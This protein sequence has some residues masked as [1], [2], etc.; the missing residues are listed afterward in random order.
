MHAVSRVR[1]ALGRIVASPYWRL[2]LVAIGITAV[3]SLVRPFD[4]YPARQFTGEDG[5]LYLEMT[6]ILPSQILE[7]K[8]FHYHIQRTF[9]SAVIWAVSRLL[10][11]PMDEAHGADRFRVLNA[12]WLVVGHGFFMATLRR[13]GVSV[14][15]AVLGTVLYFGSYL[16]A[17]YAFYYPQMTDV[18]ALGLGH[19]LAY[20]YV[21]RSRTLIL[22]VTLVGA[23]TWPYLFTLLAIPLALF[24]P[25]GGDVLSQAP[26]GRVGTLGAMLLGGLACF[27]V[28][29]VYF[30]L[31][32]LDPARF[33]WFYDGLLAAMWDKEYKKDYAPLFVLGWLPVAGVVAVA[34]AVLPASRLLRGIEL[35]DLVWRARPLLA[36]AVLG[37]AVGL[38][39]LQSRFATSHPLEETMH[40]KL[41]IQHTLTL[42]RPLLALVGHFAFL[43]PCVALFVVHWSGACF[44]ARRLGIGYAIAAAYL[45]LLLVCAETR[46]FLPGIALLLVPLVKAADD[47]GVGLPEIVVCAA[48]GA[49]TSKIWLLASLDPSAWQHPLVRGHFH[50]MPQQLYYMNIGVTM[51]REAYGWH[52]VGLAVTV[53]A[54]IAARWRCARH[55]VTGASTVGWE[56]G[57][58][59]A[60]LAGLA[61]T[62]VVAVVVAVAPRPVGL[63]AVVAT[64]DGPTAGAWLVN[65]VVESQREPGPERDDPWA[66]VDLGRAVRVEGVRI[67][68]LPGLATL[69]VETSMD[70][71]TFTHAGNE[72]AFV[73][74]VVPCRPTW[75]G[76]EAR[77]VRVIQRGRARFSPT[78]I[79]VL[80]RP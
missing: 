11:L 75:D 38:F 31:Q 40:Y 42:T 34:S 41:H 46:Q 53:A 30:G 12:I 49:A 80:G 2:S 58:L 72:L 35:R 63:G 20:A 37:L 26:R 55:P 33:P 50:E 25:R 47:R 29:R 19:V 3:V 70:G 27:V 24:L 9:P 76:R 7:H 28:Y 65:G 59:V 62:L 44:V 78:E 22:L 15:G 52:L 17:R 6:R 73:N 21:R 5:T 79:E 18:T 36:S 56:R 14:R 10:H 68:G 57:V 16:A 32:S 8:L 71:V 77:Y 61:A 1:A 74:V 23:F 13:V 54:L 51:G 69:D 66:T 43:G 67:Y 45:L 60:A 39:L 4:R 64:P 48:A